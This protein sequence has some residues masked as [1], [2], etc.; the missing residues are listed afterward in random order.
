M[1]K[2]SNLCLLIMLCAAVLV[3]ATMETGNARSGFSVASIRG[4]YRLTF[5][6]LIL[7]GLRPESGLGIFVADGQGN[8]TGTEVF[9][10]DG[11]LCPD[12]TVTA[13]YTVN[14]NGT[15]TVSADFASPTA[16]CSGHF[17]NALLLLD[18]GRVVKALGT[19]PGFV[20][21]SEEWR[22]QPE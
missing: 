7:P 6:G 1:A 8:I 18:G 21:I 14:P 3:L 15:G 9:N 5:S 11:H 19:G 13:T 12:V 16:G 20:T 2:R 22:R 17:D 4:V 10:T